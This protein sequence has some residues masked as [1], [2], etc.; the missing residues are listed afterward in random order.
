MSGPLTTTTAAGIVASSLLEDAVVRPL[1]AFAAGALLGML[2]VL[3]LH[4]GDARL[5]AAYA[6]NDA[7]RSAQAGTNDDDQEDK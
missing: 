4:R 3:A 6:A 1:A 2:A 5:A 7:A